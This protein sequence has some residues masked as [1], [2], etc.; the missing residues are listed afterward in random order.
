[1]QFFGEEYIKGIPLFRI[2]I[3]APVTMLLSNLL[4]YIFLSVHKPDIPTKISIVQSSILILSCFIFIPKIGTLGA[5]ISV[6][7]ASF[8]GS[9]LM[10]ICTEKFLKSFEDSPGKDI[11]TDN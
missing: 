1:M 10:V 2:L 8:I 6:L 7:F 9:M 5:A 4:G 11:E 3:F